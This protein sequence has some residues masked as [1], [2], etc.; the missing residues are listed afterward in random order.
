MNKFIV[1][2][3]LFG[4]KM[5]TEVFA[6]SERDAKKRIA[7]KIVFHKIEPVEETMFKNLKDIFPFL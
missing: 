7:E 6:K 3:E 5:K 4:K 2:F 1:Y